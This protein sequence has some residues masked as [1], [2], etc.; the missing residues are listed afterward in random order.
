[1]IIGLTGKKGCGKS[2]VG[3]IIAEEWGYGIKS[4][5][6]PI[7]LMLSAM[8]LSDDELY[9]PEKKEEI[10]PE[11]G[12]SP[13]ELMQL[14]G[15]EFGR[16]LVSQNIWVASLEKHLEQGQSYVIDDVRFPN[17]AAMIRANGGIVVRIVRGLDD[18]VP[19][20]ISEA[21]IDTELINYEI[22]NISCYESDLE[23]EVK[24]VLKEILLDGTVCNTK[25]TG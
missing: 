23:L 22:R 17:E 16:T 19:E 24:R 20:H 11:F 8:G 25:S 14:L 21:G 2:T 6:T 1:M 12:K 4:F 7:K 15:T 18:E 10:I 9:N 3:R 5:A 13:R